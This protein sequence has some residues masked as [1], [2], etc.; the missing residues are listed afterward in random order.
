MLKEF[1]NK[2]KLTIHKSNIWNEPNLW[3][4][5][6][7]NEFI[8]SEDLID[9]MEHH[10]DRINANDQFNLSALK[11]VHHFK[12][13]KQKSYTTFTMYKKVHYKKSRSNKII[14][15]YRR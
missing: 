12:L 11:F 15:E 10:W 8:Y 2:H 4:V 13:L 1:M 9:I 6:W 3:F 7:H 14:K 5:K